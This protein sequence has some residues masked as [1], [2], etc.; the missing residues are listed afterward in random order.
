MA[1]SEG[2]VRVTVDE[3]R[4]SKRARKGKE[5]RKSINH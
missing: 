3:D 5:N 1:E 4:D 2:N